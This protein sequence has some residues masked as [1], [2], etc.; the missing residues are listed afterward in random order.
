MSEHDAW[1]AARRVAARLRG[2]GH[3]A[4]I[5]GGA[6]RDHLLGRAPHDVDVATAARPEEILAI[7][8]DARR[9]GA[10]FGVVLVREGEHWIEAATFRREGVY[11]DGRRPSEV[12]F[13]TLDEDAHRRDFTVNGLYLDPTT[14]EIRDLV[15]GR[16]DLEARCLRAIGD[17]VARL[18]EDRLRL[19]RAIRLAAQLD[20]EIEAETWSAI[21]ALS[22]LAADVAA[23]RTRDEIL[24]LLSGPGA[25]RG[26]VL[27]KESGLLEV[28]LPEVAAMDGVEQPI[29]YHPE[30]DVLRHTALLFDYLEKPS[31]ELALGALLHDVGKPPTFECGSAGIRF[32]AHAKIGAEIADRICERLRLSTASRERVVELVAE[33]MRFLDVQRMKPSTLKRFLRQPKFDEHLAL[34]RADC[35][36]SN[37]R[38]DNWEFARRTREE[39][40]EDDLRPRP[41]ADGHDLMAMGWAPGPALGAELKRLEELQ[42]EGRLATRE[43]ALAE[44]RRTLE[45]AGA[46]S[47]RDVGPPPDPETD[48]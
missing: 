15:G 39:L 31:P 18:R 40:P 33:H 1:N 20:F 16:R 28:L 10:A 42:L 45:R 25:S 32:P 29:E 46:G 35:L 48:G 12:T 7:W 3:E 41:L 21:R 9:V 6:V 47:G 14:G 22:P 36:A 13:G 24:R 17:P 11:L 2:D 44:A 30:G 38:L 43:D 37:G 19:L 26:V 8:P 34:H 4:W 27:L 5:A 23:E